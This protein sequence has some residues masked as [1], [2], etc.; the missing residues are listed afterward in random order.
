MPAYKLYYFTAR[1]AAEMS[2]FVFAQAGVE[3]EDVRLQFGGEEWLKMKPGELAHC[4]TRLH[5]EGRSYAAKRSPSCCTQQAG[6]FCFIH[7]MH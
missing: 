7:G 3:Y 6:C 2:R 1:G 4:G 5:C